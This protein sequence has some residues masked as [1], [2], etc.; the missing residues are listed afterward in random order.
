MPSNFQQP[1]SE[2][3]RKN[4]DNSWRAWLREYRIVAIFIVLIALLLTGLQDG[5]DTLRTNLLL[6]FCIGTL[7]FV[8][9]RLCIMALWETDDDIP[10]F[11][12]TIVVLASGVVAM[13]VGMLLGGSLLGIPIEKIT[14]AWQIQYERFLTILL[15][16][17]T[18]T[19]LV[20]WISKK[21]TQLRNSIAKE[22]LRAE[23]NARQATQ[24]QLQMLQAQIEPHM[25]FN[26]LANVQ[27]LI[28]LDPSR[29]SHMLDQLILYLRATLQSARAE[30]T[31]LGQEFAL[32][33]AYLDLMQI[34]MGS[35]LSF[36]FILPKELSNIQIAPLLLQPLVEN[37]IKHGLEPKIEGGQL[38][39]QA[40]LNGNLLHL[41]VADNG[42]GLDAPAQHGTQLGL[43]NIRER[44]QALYGPHA[45][46]SLT[47][48]AAGGTQAAVVLP[49]QN[50]S[51]QNKT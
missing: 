18:A 28:N 2:P 9:E 14:R 5:K 13:A 11:G 41:S 26:T 39:V 46:L 49:L 1:A 23:S 50:S 4:R 35:R 7:A 27:C 17:A 51:F 45:S 47:P 34:R 40:Q 44:L 8:L 24:A 21:M 25:L 31:S 16:A 22:R 36:Q 43:S 6:S 19:M 20:F 15:I 30:K 12:M 42:L 10:F 37:A 32:M 48:S 38:T 29:A 33:Q 3:V